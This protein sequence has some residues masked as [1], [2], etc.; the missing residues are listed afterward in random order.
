MTMKASGTK[1]SR[2]TAVSAGGDHLAVAAD[3]GR[4]HRP[5][6]RERLPHRA[7]ESLP[8]ARRVDG[9]VERCDDLGNVGPVSGLDDL[10]RKARR[11]DH[12]RHLLAVGLVPR[13]QELRNIVH[14]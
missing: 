1:S 14:V 8:R 6:D 9:D 3:V 13:E 2:A 12:A 11:L 5:P 10:A 7:R 4:D